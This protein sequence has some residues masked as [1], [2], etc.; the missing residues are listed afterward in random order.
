MTLQ[1][2]T[3]M[4]V[5]FGYYLLTEAFFGIPLAALAVSLDG[6]LLFFIGL[7]IVQLQQNVLS[8]RFSVY[9]TATM[10]EVSWSPLSFGEFLPVDLAMSPDGTRLFVLAGQLDLSQALVISLYA[11]DPIFS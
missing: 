9:D 6:G 4:Q 1:V 3:Q 7:D 8:S 2:T 11:V 5:G 10:Q